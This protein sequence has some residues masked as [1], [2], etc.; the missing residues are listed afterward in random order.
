MHDHVCMYAV[1]VVAVV[2][3]VVL[4]ACLFGSMHSHMQVSRK[5]LDRSRA[6]KMEYIYIYVIHG[7]IDML[8]LCVEGGGSIQ[9]NLPIPPDV[10]FKTTS[11]RYQT[12]RDAVPT[13][14][15]TRVAPG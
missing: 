14:I 2:A 9:L 11:L 7:Y 13:R 10:A 5:A 1:A 3:V 12:M 4:V 8:F 6:I 15:C